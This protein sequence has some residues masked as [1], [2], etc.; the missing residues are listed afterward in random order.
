MKIVY[1]KSVSY[2]Q[3]LS[4]F[5]KIAYSKMLSAYTYFI[6]ILS[7]IAETAYR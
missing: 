6:M 1:D 5:S 3:R 2:I 7:E 4:A